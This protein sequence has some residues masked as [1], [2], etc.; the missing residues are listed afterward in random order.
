MLCQENVVWPKYSDLL[1]FFLEC[2]ALIAQLHEIQQTKHRCSQYSGCLHV[3]WALA[4]M[5]GSIWALQVWVWEVL[6]SASMIILRYELSRFKIRRIIFIITQIIIK[7]NNL[8]NWKFYVVQHHMRLKLLYSAYNTYLQ[9]VRKRYTYCTEALT[10]H[11]SWF[12]F[13][14]TDRPLNLVGSTF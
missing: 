5:L 1:D 14:P 6:I 2:R 12:A 4:Q 8:L 10:Y 11:L 9:L 7:I 3:L 13:G